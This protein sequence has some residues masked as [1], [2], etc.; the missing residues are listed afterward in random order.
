MSVSTGEEV[1]LII[2]QAIQWRQPTES[3]LHST[4]EILTYIIKNIWTLIHGT[5]G[6]FHLYIGILF[7]FLYFIFSNDE[8]NKQHQ[9]TFETYATGHPLQSC[10]YRWYAKRHKRTKHY[11]HWKREERRKYR[12]PRPCSWSWTDTINEITT[13]IY[14]YMSKTAQSN[15]SHRKQTRSTYRARGKR[16]KRRKKNK[17]K[18]D[19]L[20]R[21]WRIISEEE[22]QEDY[23][24]VKNKYLHHSFIQYEMQY[25]V[26]IDEFCETIDPLRQ[27]AMENIVKQAEFLEQ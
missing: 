5:Q 14:N 20:P 2:K 10:N 18:K 1:K 6:E 9:F 17:I 25:G 3:F 7:T 16:R 19:N 21:H 23:E 26:D 4:K 22:R 8:L 11:H 13:T 24:R 12:K 15:N 27:F